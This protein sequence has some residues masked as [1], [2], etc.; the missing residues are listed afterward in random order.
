MLGIEI[1][2]HTFE[3]ISDFDIMFD[4]NPFSVFVERKCYNF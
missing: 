2:N 4:R 1:T 3:P